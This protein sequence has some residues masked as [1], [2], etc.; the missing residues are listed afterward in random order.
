MIKGF[1]ASKNVSTYFRG[2][3][4]TKLLT[5]KE[6]QLLSTLIHQGDSEAF[7]IMVQSNLKLVVKLANRHVGQGVPIDDLIQ[8]G[9][10]GLM[11][12]ARRYL[13]NTTARFATY[14][15]LWI[16]KR[17]NETVAQTGRIVRLPHNQEIELYRA[18]KAKISEE[19]GDTPTA[20]KTVRLDTPVGEEG[21]VSLGDLILNTPSQ[22]GI[23][24]EVDDLNFRVHRLVREL[25]PRDK[26]I[27]LDY[28]GIDRDYELP[29]DII[30]EKYNMTNVRVSQIVKSSLA[31][32]RQLV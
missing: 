27:I 13:P 32:L 31:T 5:K 11:E 23:D 28:F 12:A 8:E 1:E 24:M 14:A 17:L 2:F 18:G 10:I 16:R 29:T 7:D 15:S 21:G 20:P 19:F 9:N 4:K 6:E 3:Q 25:K 22:T 30:A 26:E